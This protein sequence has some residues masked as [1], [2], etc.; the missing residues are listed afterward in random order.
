VAVAFSTT[1]ALIGFL[2]DLKRHFP[3]RRLLL[4]WDGLPSHKSRDMTAYLRAQRSW[5]AV[6]RLPGYAPELNPAEL[7]WGNVNGR[8]LANLCADNLGGRAGGPRRPPARPAR[9]HTGVRFSPARRSF[10]LIGLSL[11]YARFNKV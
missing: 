9:P 1:V 7:V 2:N 10:F 4:I 5:L 11:Y 6:E 8:D 3:R